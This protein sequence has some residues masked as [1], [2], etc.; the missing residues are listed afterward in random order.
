MDTKG[1]GTL[2]IL[3]GGNLTRALAVQMVLEESSLAYELR[4]VDIA[5]QEHRSEAFR[6]INPAGYVPALITPE[7]TVLHEAAAI[8]LWLADRHAIEEMAPL[9]TDPLRGV[10]LAKLFYFTNDI[11]PALKHCYY[12]RRWTLRDGDTPAFRK[13]SQAMAAER[14]QILEDWL[15]A[16]GPYHL[17]DR[18]SL[19][20][21]HL[22]VWVC[23]GFDRTLDILETMP[24]T[25]RLFDLVHA[26]PVSGPLLDNLI[27][28]LDS[29][30]DDP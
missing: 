14:W 24:A 26:R 21:L 10:F 25:R 7:G 6:A 22:S 16:N 15:E 9:P 30:R 13:H 11:Q 23:Y 28:T 8:C 17:G 12:P 3:Y 2:Y 19:L 1:V 4:N 27:A 18:L 20:D 5:A 29:H